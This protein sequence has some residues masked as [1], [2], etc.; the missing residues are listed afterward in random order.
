MGMGAVFA[1]MVTLA[2]TKDP[3]KYM[4][5]TESWVKQLEYHGIAREKQLILM[6]ND[7]TLETKE[8]VAGLNTLVREV[9]PLVVESGEE[10]KS[11]HHQPSKFWLWSFTEFDKIVSC[12][13]VGVVV[14]V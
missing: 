9:E 7:V 2:N 4:D 6:T 10:D 5:M 12:F 3:K 14:H 11:Y 8:R 1:T 13:H